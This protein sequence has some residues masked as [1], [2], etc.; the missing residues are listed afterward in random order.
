MFQGLLEFEGQRVEALVRAEL[1][2]IRLRCVE[3][4]ICSFNCPVGIDIRR[5]VQEGLSISDD[6]CLA[7]GECVSRCPRGVLHF[8]NS[9]IFSHEKSR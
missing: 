2:A 7:C 4:G 3:C 1:Q 8:Q 5:H 9:G 6:R